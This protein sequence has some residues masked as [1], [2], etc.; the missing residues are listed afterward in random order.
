MNPRY[1][2][3]WWQSVFILYKFILLLIWHVVICS[4]IWKCS[5]FD[6]SVY[7]VELILICLG[8]QWHSWSRHC[9]ICWKVLVSFVSGVIGIFIDIIFQPHCGT[10][11]DWTCNRHEYQEYFLPGEKAD[12]LATFVYCLSGNL[13]DSTSWNIQGLSRPGQ[14]CFTFI[15]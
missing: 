6:C 4:I 7:L 1:P 3:K 9:N 13:G 8:M 10:G 14:E 5:S 11:I 2:I 12:N 15:L